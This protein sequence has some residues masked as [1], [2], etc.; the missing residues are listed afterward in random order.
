MRT[1]SHGANLDDVGPVEAAIDEYGRVEA[2]GA[3]LPNATTCFAPA[4]TASLFVVVVPSL[5]HGRP[6]QRWSAE[7]VQRARLMAEVKGSEFRAT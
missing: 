3:I 5:T 2:L 6:P 4:S 1:T 7:H